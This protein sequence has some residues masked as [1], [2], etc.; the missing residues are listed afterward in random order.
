M[1]PRVRL[2]DLAGPVLVGGVRQPRLALVVEEP[3][4]WVA[5]ERE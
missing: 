4:D 1:R 5:Q 2:E 3:A